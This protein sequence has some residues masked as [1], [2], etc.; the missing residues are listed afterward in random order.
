MTYHK[1]SNNFVLQPQLFFIKIVFIMF[2]NLDFLSTRLLRV[3]GVLSVRATPRIQKK[4]SCFYAFADNVR[5]M[6]NITINNKLS[7]FA[8]TSPCQINGTRL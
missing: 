6:F 8:R 5:C 1:T 4:T 3:L 2:E 7:Q